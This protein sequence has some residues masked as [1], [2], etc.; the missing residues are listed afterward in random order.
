LRVFCDGDSWTTGS[1]AT[2]QFHSW[3]TQLQILAQADSNCPGLVFVGPVASGDS[4]YPALNDHN[5]DNGSGIATHNGAALATNLTTYYPDVLILFLGY[6]DAVLGP[7]D[8]PTYKTYFTD[9]FAARPGMRMLWTCQPDL[10]SQPNLA[11]FGAAIPGATADLITAAPTMQIVSHDFTGSITAGDTSASHPTAA[12]YDLL[13]ASL[14][15]KF[16]TL[17]G[18]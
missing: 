17:I 2:P 8:V 14:W 16:K 15:P 18:I 11:A 5:G 6:N 12:G 13:A 10:F 4:V 7:V 1:T 9:A 3:R